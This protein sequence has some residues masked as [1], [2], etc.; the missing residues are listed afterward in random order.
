MSA[1]LFTIVIGL[2]SILAGFLGSLTGIGGGAVIIPLLTLLFGVDIRYAIGAS[3][4]AVIA[5]S[6]GGA[7]ALCQRRLYQYPRWHV[8]GSRKPLPARLFGA[9]LATILHTSTLAVIFGLILIFSSYQSAMAHEDDSE[10]ATSPDPLAV[11][12]RMD[13]SYPTSEGLKRYHV[14]S[15][16][17]GFAMMLGAGAISGLLGI[18]AGVI[19]VLAMDRA[20]KLPSRSRPLPATS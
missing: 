5:T 14:R 18:G 4:I 10:G 19:K 6:S 16:P 1:L 15:V 7:A 3:L 2:G 17:T 8:P 11:R 20:M 13:S 12:L 9:F